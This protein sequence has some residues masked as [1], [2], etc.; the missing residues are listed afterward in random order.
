MAVWTARLPGAEVIPFRLVARPLG[1]GMGVF[2]WPDAVSNR[3]RGVGP[4]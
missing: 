2:R 4:W 1:E 3:R